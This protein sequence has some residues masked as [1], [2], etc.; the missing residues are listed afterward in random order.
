MRPINTPIHKNWNV[1]F[2]VL[3]AA[4]SLLYGYHDIFF[5]RPWSIHQWRQCDCLS[6]TYNYYK[7]GM[8]F[9]SP[10]VHWSGLKGDGKT[11]TSECPWLYYLIACLWQIFGYHEFIYRMVDTAIAFCGL[12]FLFK[13]CREVLQDGVWSIFVAL[14]LFTS[15]IFAYYG[16]SFLTDV[17]ALSIALVAWYYFY[18]FY[19]EGTNRY[20]YVW[21][22]FCLLAGLTKITALL[23]F[24]P[25]FLIFPIEALGIYRFKESGNIFEKPLQKIIPVILFIAIILSW[26]LYAMHYNKVH[27]GGVFST[28]T[29]PIWTTEIHEIQ[30]ISRRLFNELLPM[31]FNSAFL[32]GVLFLFLSIIL[33]KKKVNRLLL[34]LCYTIFLG[35]LLYLLLWFKVFTVHDYY[36]TNLLI[37]IPCV[38]ITFLYYLK[39]NQPNLFQSSVLKSIAAAIFLINTYYCTVQIRLRYFPG[40][41]FVRYSFILDEPI[42]NYWTWYHWD[43]NNYN[44]SLET[45]TPYLRSLGIK[46]EDKVVSLPDNSI[47]I[48][49]YLM[50]QKG[51]TE[52]SMAPGEEKGALQKFAD[53]G[54]KYLVISNP[55]LIDSS[56]VKPFTGKKLGQYKNVSIFDLRYRMTINDTINTIIQTIKNNHTWYSNI[57]RGAKENNIPMDSALKLNA[58]W[59]L[60]NKQ[61]KF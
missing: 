52:Y 48:S 53:H 21:L 43:Y 40:S 47:N 8:H 60:K 59:L 50:D 3:L 36:L 17:P 38:L 30:F 44:K 33:L 58:L 16:N 10:E 46:R 55:D 19:K 25:I 31:Y 2:F 32:L 1:I 35:C 51:Y 41:P 11:S 37:F 28:Q 27:N 12:Y 26:T 14:F 42:L 9:F 22:F 54:A 23:S 34:F 18:K 29:F 57:E 49:L 39:R 56:W 6:I 20:F 4:M 45:I 13:L 24:V 61:F 7:E 15:P 5:M